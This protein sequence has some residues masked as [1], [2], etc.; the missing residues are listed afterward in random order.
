MAEDSEK[1]G[2]SPQTKTILT[3]CAVGGGAVLG[4][5]ALGQLPIVQAHPWGWLAGAGAA[6]AGAAALRT[7]KPAIAL[8]LAVSAV[9]LAIQ[10]FQHRNDVPPDAVDPSAAPLGAPAAAGPALPAPSSAAAG[11]FNNP[12]D[13]NGNTIGGGSS[14]PIDNPGAFGAGDFGGGSAD[15]AGGGGLDLFSKISGLFGPSGG[16]NISDAGLVVAQALGRR[17]R[18]R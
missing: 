17:G 10:G 2:M 5:N 11:G 18:R 6:G 13:K 1:K 16:S 15:N 12:L 14:T 7:K 3:A 4:A 8:G 9:I